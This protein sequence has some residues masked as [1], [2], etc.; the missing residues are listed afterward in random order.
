MSN[1][2]TP[3]ASVINSLMGFASGSIAGRSGTA[4]SPRN[5]RR[6]CAGGEL[7][8]ADAE[9]EAAHPR[10]VAG[11]EVTRVADAVV[12]AVEQ[13][14][15]IGR[16]PGRDRWDHSSRQRRCRRGCRCRRGTFRSRPCTSRW[17]R[18]PRWPRDTPSP[19][20][21][22][23][24]PANSSRPQRSCRRRTPHRSSTRHCR[25]RA[26]RM[27]ARRPRSGSRRGRLRRSR[28]YASDVPPANWAIS[29][30]VVSTGWSSIRSIGHWSQAM[31]QP[32]DI[33]AVRRTPRHPD[34]IPD[35]GPPPAPLQ[36]H[37]G[38]DVAIGSGE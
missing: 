10:Q 3:R 38:S 9:P 35:V 6:C 13:R 30:D 12:V 28:I 17:R 11:A 8:L 36:A 29:V 24:S 32:C 21:R 22:S 7:E 34:C 15:G 18:T 4:R 33:R 31:W 1:T 20:P 37:L 26:A 14:I 19:E 25:N 2:V 5:S 16:Q 27:R 23:D